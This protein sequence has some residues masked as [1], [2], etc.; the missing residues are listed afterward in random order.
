MNGSSVVLLAQCERGIRW[1]CL[2]NHSSQ[3]VHTYD[4]VHLLLRLIAFERYLV[5][6]RVDL[7]PNRPVRSDEFASNLSHCD[8]LHD[9]SSQHYRS[10]SLLHSLVALLVCE[11]LHRVIHGERKKQESLE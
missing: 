2:S 3:W 9:L 8:W 6:V 1:R 7:V 5:E 11:F 10:L 4:H